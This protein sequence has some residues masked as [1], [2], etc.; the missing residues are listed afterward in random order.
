MEIDG[1]WIEVPFW[2]WRI[3]NPIRK[4]LFARNIGSTVELSDQHEWQTS[5]PLADFESQFLEIQTMPD[6]AIRPRALMTTMFSR[7]VLSDLFLHGIGG[8]KYDQLTD[9]IAERFFGV[10]LPAYATMSATMKL[11]TDREIIRTSDVI[12]T[13][14]Q[15][16]EVKFHPETQ[17]ANP[18]EAARALIRQKDQWTKGFRRDERSLEKHVAISELNEQ[19]QAFV[20]V[21][22]LTLKKKRDELAKKT[23]A[24][25]I[26]DSRE[27][28]FCLFPESLIDELSDL[29]KIQT[30]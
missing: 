8:A 18:D 13:E 30:A 16:R 7:M 11:P 19:L 9:V 2:V 10:C 15:I 20:D 1:D 6:V 22:E 24:S 5:I 4:R 17:I 23:R 29:A 27:Y 25:E 28:S 14:Q 12:A 21:D 3:E 26:L